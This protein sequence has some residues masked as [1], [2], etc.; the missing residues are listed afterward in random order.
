M[1]P[2]STIKK[3]TS[4]SSANA[5]SFH[6]GGSLPCST[7]TQPMI[8]GVRPIPSRMWALYTRLTQ[9]PAYPI[10]L[11]RHSKG[12][13]LPSHF[14]SLCYLWEDNGMLV[15]NLNLRQQLRIQLSKPNTNFLMQLAT[16]SAPCQLKCFGDYGSG[17]V[18]NTE[19]PDIFDRKNHRSNCPHMGH[20]E[21]GWMLFFALLFPA[22]LVSSTVVIGRGPTPVKILFRL[23]RGPSASK[24]LS[25]A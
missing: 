5:L 9:A 23:R 24:H 7:L 3:Q 21:L 19:Y 13:S 4:Q 22:E 11:L 15:P 2:G 8:F 20:N 6:C 25:P 1:T 14:T 18:N 10:P 17:L 16:W 12:R